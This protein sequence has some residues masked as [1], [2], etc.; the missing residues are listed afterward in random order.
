MRRAGKLNGALRWS[1]SDR[2]IPARAGKTRRTKICLESTGAHPRAGGENTQRAGSC[3]TPAGSSPRGRGKRGRR[4]KGRNLRGL[5]P[6]RAGKTCDAR[7]P[8]SPPGAHPR[9]GGE[10]AGPRRSVD[11][12]AGSSPRGRGKR[13]GYADRRPKPRLIPARAGKTRP[14]DQPRPDRPAHPRAGGENSDLLDLCLRE[15]G[16]SPRGRGKRPVGWTS[17]G[18]NGLIPARAGKTA[19]RSTSIQRARAHPRA[20]G[21]NSTA[22]ASLW[23]LLGSSPRGRGKRP[24]RPDASARLRLIPARAGKTTRQTR[25]IRSLAAHPRAGGENL[26]PP[27]TCSPPNG[28]S[29]RGR[30]KPCNPPTPMLT[31]GLIPAR[32]GKTGRGLPN[33]GPGQ[34]HPRA[35]GENVPMRKRPLAVLGSSPRG[36]GKHL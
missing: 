19:S 2:L 36:R 14:R 27:S 12:G 34:A 25:R 26:P 22:S 1:L 29:P 21:E 7:S 15:A 32:A 10:N 28:S 24:D 18:W 9:A 8:D 35:G 30:G 4:R 23:R 3:P 11:L 20:G 6:A 13:A 5:I 17:T 31:T 33:H 16:S